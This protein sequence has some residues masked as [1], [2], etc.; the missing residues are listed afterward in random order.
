MDEKQLKVEQ[1]YLARELFLADIK[2]GISP[3]TAVR[4]AWHFAAMFIDIA[5]RNVIVDRKE[6]GDV[7]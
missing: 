5:R 1:F 3:G 7:Q 6:P 2:A 4:S